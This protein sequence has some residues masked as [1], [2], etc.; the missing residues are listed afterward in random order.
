MAQPVSLCKLVRT[1]VARKSP[2]G[3]FVALLKQLLQ[4]KSDISDNELTDELF[5][6]QGSSP[7]ARR[8]QLEYALEYASLGIPELMRF[9]KLLPHT[10]ENSQ[11]EYVFYL[12]N[13]FGSIFRET[14]LKTFVTEGL[15]SY[16][17]KVSSDIAAGGASLEKKA[18]FTQILFLWGAVIDR[19]AAIIVRPAF[20]EL[21]IGVMRA[22]GSA[23]Q[24]Q[25]TAFFTRKANVI[26]NSLDLHRELH[27]P[28]NTPAATK[29]ETV[30]MAN[31]K[32][33]YT[34][35]GGGSKYAS[36][37]RLKKFIWLKYQ[38]LQWL[39]ENLLDRY[40]AFFNIGTQNPA[41]VIDEIVNAFFG[42]ILVAIILREKTYVVFNWKNFIVCTLPDSLKTSRIS[43]VLQLADNAEDLLAK[44]VLAYSMN[45]ITQ[46]HVGGVKDRPYDLRK[47]FLR[48]C[49]H[50]KIISLETFTTT[51][52]EEADNIS[53][54]LIAHETGQLDQV[55]LLTLEVNSKLMNINTEFT[56]LEESKL[57]EFFQSLPSTNLAYLTRKQEQL[58][59]LAHSLVDSFVR[60]KNNEKLSR[61]L[62][63]MLNCLPVANYIF[64]NE[65][66][67]PLNML[68]K[69]ITYIDGESFSVEDD[70]SNFQDTYAYFGIILSGVVSIA[71]FFGVDLHS[72]NMK[73][74]YTVDYINKFY[75]RLCDDLTNQVKS[76]DEDESTIASNY[77]NL[78]GDWVNA[79]F[80]VSNDGLSDDLLKSVNVKQIYKLIFIIFQRAVSARVVGSLSVSSLNNG[81]DYLSQNF[82][83]PCSMEVIQ[84]IVTKIGPKLPCSDAM[85]QILLRILECN[86]GES[87][88]NGVSG[89]NFTFRMILNILAPEIFR[90]LKSI[91][92]GQS[93]VVVKITNILRKEVDHEYTG[94]GLVPDQVFPGKLTMADTIKEEIIQL[95]REHVLAD[96]T[97]IGKI[98]QKISQCWLAL[99]TVEVLY[100]VERELEG[101]TKTR[102]YS[103]SSEEAKIFLDFLVFMLIASSCLKREDVSE[104]ILSLQKSM[105]RSAA[106]CGDKAFELSMDHHFSSIFNE[107]N[108]AVSSPRGSVK[109]EDAPKVDLMTDF[110][111]DDLFNDISE[112][113]FGDPLAQVGGNAPQPATSAAPANTRKVYHEVRIA[114]TPLAQF[115]QILGFAEVL[116][117]G[118]LS[119][120][121]R[122]RLV[123]ELEQWKA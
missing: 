117:G 75:F 69:L 8:L 3:L 31:I 39:L 87:Q 67:G 60:E 16:T 111:M 89:P 7:Q 91:K 54:A 55:D 118:Q 79:L 64:F 12:K 32:K 11:K 45:Q 44:A 74:S 70:D 82:L 56:S 97:A 41:E 71:V 33:L 47:A 18:V 51:F 9:M 36:Y 53:P 63:A 88:A 22:L 85:M 30:S 49:I 114:R 115:V 37:V 77:N 112:D 98:W 14:L 35:P 1:S 46:L 6:L 23:G 19:C 93:D 34:V 17:A 106:K 20:K 40:F 38:F 21:A 27:I 108:D 66:Q 43:Q 57:I 65:S 4:R 84:W 90:R 105:A 113:L 116:V 95:T 15:P 59:K 94:Y 107:T 2:K 86:V 110:E 52:P 78:F 101:C 100:G 102:S 13:H 61:F 5:S 96:F 120:L 50:K 119:S 62:L 68:Y 83:V 29:T 24:P 81:V 103:H 123:H 76:S 42:G 121:A 58:S 73:S 109:E 122:L 104:Y 10:P 80:D 26:L 72:V 25:M 48:S 28:A 92:T 99:P